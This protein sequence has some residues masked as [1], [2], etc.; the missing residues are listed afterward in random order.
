[1]YSFL[2]GSQILKIEDQRGNESRI[3]DVQP[4]RFYACNIQELVL[5]LIRGSI[6]GKIEPE[7][8]GKTNT[9]TKG[10][11]AEIEFSPRVSI[12]ALYIAIPSSEAED[13]VSPLG[14][15]FDG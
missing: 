1:M 10:I 8:R 13:I 5:I 4:R 7:V 3:G 12:R 6:I 9:E 11:S 15:Q 14:S 2:S